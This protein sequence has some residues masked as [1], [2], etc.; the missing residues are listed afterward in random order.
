MQHHYDICG[1]AFPMRPILVLFF[2]I[3]VFICAC[4]K[5]ADPQPPPSP[6]Q[7]TRIEK[8]DISNTV[9]W[10]GSD[11]KNF[12]AYE[13]YAW[14]TDQASD[15]PPLSDGE[16]IAKITDQNVRSFRHDSVYFY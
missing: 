11:I 1:H 16:L 4:K 10:S 2:S 9:Y 3:V 5:S 13:V 12:A 15:I 7:I 8:D 6:V 14:Y